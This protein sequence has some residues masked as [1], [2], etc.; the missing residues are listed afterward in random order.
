MSH[1]L[2]STWH[3]FLIPSHGPESGLPTVAVPG[4]DS[5]YPPLQVVTMHLLAMVNWDRL[6]QICIYWV[7]LSHDE[8]RGAMRGHD[9][10]RPQDVNP[11]PRAWICMRALDPEVSECAWQSPSVTRTTPGKTWL[12]FPEASGME[13][14]DPVNRKNIQEHLDTPGNLTRNIKNLSIWALWFWGDQSAAEKPQTY[15]Y[16]FLRDPH[17]SR[18][19]ARS[20][21]AL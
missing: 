18:P 10:P 9:C 16:N 13:A 12:V 14:N 19:V 17:V 11:R 20:L 7:S 8:N 3:N 1:E 6:S 4:H 2:I 21:K 15:F 5:F